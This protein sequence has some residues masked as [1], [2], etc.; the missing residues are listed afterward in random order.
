MQNVRLIREEALRLRSESFQAKL[1]ESNDEYNPYS[2]VRVNGCHPHIGSGFYMHLPKL[3]GFAASIQ[4]ISSHEPLVYEDMPLPMTRDF[5]AVLRKEHEAFYPAGL[6]MTVTDKYLTCY[7]PK[8][9]SDQKFRHVSMADFLDCF[10]KYTQDPFR[11]IEVEVSS[12][13]EGIR[14]EPSVYRCLRL[15]YLLAGTKRVDEAEQVLALGRNLFSGRDEFDSKYFEK[16]L[17]S[18]V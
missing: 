17:S 8:M 7:A 9:D 6:W 1:I 11:H 14:K 4:F 12:L 13:K 5:D 2:A 10:L 3:Y 16:L 18:L 15:A